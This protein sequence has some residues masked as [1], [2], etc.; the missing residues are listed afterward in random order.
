M[1]SALG[2]GS[3][4]IHKR[5]Q[6]G[7]EISTKSGA[8]TGMPASPSSPVVQVQ[9]GQKPVCDAPAPRIKIEVSAFGVAEDAA[10]ENDQWCKAAQRFDVQALASLV[11]RSVNVDQ[12]LDSVRGLGTSPLFYR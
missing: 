11:E 3:L 4:K 7:N 12:E 9:A 8:S 6:S 10:P 2:F 5:K 1:K